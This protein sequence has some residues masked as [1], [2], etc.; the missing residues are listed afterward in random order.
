[1][2]SVISVAE[3]T[4]VAEVTV[5]SVTSATEITEPTEF[6]NFAD[7]LGLCTRSS[8]NDPQHW[9]TITGMRRN[10]TYY[11]YFGVNDDIVIDEWDIQHV[12]AEHHVDLQPRQTKS[13]TF[14]PDEPSRDS[15][16]LQI[17]VE[18]SFEPY[19]L[20]PKRVRT[21]RIGFNTVPVW[22]DAVNK[23]EPSSSVS[24]LSI[25]ENSGSLQ[26]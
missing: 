16:T 21:L 18:L 23:P 2:G 10:Q 8:P 25:E 1:M 4:E 14:P 26:A 3:V 20:N 11:T 13:F 7:A 17:Q 15:V 24:V 19:V 9:A 5:G 12:C 22:H 6:S